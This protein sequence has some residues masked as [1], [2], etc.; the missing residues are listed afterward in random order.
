MLRYSTLSGWIAP[1]GRGLF[2]KCDN[3]TFDASQRRAQPTMVDFV[4]R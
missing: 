1:C 4:R 2:E 3:G